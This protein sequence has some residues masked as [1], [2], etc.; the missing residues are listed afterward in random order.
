MSLLWGMN[1]AC[2]VFTLGP[3]PAVFS[4][5]FQFCDQGSV[6]NTEVWGTT[7]CWMNPGLPHINHAF[8][9]LSY[10]SGPGERKILKTD[11]ILEN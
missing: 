4:G 11:S 6:L 5:Y 9:P 10:L 1:F 2:M 3:Y 7:W 8:S